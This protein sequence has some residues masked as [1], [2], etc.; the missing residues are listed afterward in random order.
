VSSR[1][2]RATACCAM[3]GVRLLRRIL[4]LLTLTDG[5][6]RKVHYSCDVYFAVMWGLITG[7][8]SLFPWFYPLFFVAMIAH[9]AQRDI[10]RCE[11]KYGASWSE[12][13]RQVP[14]LFI[15]VSWIHFRGRG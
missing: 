9:R 10:T 3:G 7:F 11:K 14:W 8:N 13:T 5:L 2:T 4:Q 1:R 12:Y 6:A 15:P